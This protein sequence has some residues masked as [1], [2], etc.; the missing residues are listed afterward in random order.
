MILWRGPWVVSVK[1][2]AVIE[3]L[4][5]CGD[6][7][8]DHLTRVSHAGLY[9]STVQRS[10]RDTICVGY[11]KRTMDG[12]LTFG[13]IRLLRGWL[14]RNCYLWSW[15]GIRWRFGVLIRNSCYRIGLTAEQRQVPYQR[16]L[17]SSRIGQT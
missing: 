2:W 10:P 11:S 1:L 4:F 9:G 8:P 3:P 5:R 17:A 16:P 14:L 7:T 6:G 12:W 13:Q 15:D